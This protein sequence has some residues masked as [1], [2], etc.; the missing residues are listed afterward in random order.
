MSNSIDVKLTR[1]QAC[2]ILEKLTQEYEYSEPC[3][4][5]QASLKFHIRHLGIMA[6]LSEALEIRT[7]YGMD[8]DEM[9]KRIKGGAK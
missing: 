4:T 8:P 9:L 3:F 7:W 5:D 1:E 2:H 6:L